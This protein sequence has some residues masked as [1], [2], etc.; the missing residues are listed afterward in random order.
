MTQDGLGGP[1]NSTKP[2]VLHIY[3]TAFHKFDMGSASAATVVLFAIL[4][5]ITLIQ[6]KLLGKKP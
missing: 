6:M 1:V 3:Q 4:M 5:L 2:I